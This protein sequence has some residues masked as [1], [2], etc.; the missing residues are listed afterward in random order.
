MSCQTLRR[1]SFLSWSLP[2]SK[3][4][5][6][7]A[8]LPGPA[9]LLTWA[10]AWVAWTEITLTISDFFYSSQIWWFPLFIKVR[11]LLFFCLKEYSALPQE[12]GGGWGEEKR[13]G[14]LWLLTHRNKEGIHSNCCTP[15]ATSK[16][17]IYFK[18]SQFPQM[19][20]H[21]ATLLFHREWF[22]LFWK[23]YSAPF[24][25]QHMFRFMISIIFTKA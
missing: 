4:H 13:S 24:Y 12:G 7:S 15:S 19:S 14:K 6:L 22:N 25:D 23:K 16:T 8:A 20:F 18:S 1:A 9:G 21:V 2:V 5:A 11:S 3:P 10:Q 17:T